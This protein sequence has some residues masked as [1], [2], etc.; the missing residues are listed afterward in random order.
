MAQGD[1]RSALVTF[2]RV[3]QARPEFAEAWN[4]RATL[5]YLMGEFTLSMQDIQQTLALEPRHFGA[6]SGMGQILL[7]QNKLRDARSAFH[8]ALE[9]NPHLHGARLNIIQ[10]DKMLS[11]NSV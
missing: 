9:I 4:R 3:T 10:I 11:E 8:K 7:R 5:L 2:T 1:F 6:I